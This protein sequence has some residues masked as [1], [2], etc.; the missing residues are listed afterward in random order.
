MMIYELQRIWQ[1]A[2]VASVMYSPDIHL[3]G[4]QSSEYCVTHLC[5]NG[6]RILFVFGIWYLFSVGAWQM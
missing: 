3:K 1:E 5:Q 6:G 2:V 4:L